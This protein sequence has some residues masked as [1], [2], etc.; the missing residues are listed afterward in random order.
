MPKIEKIKKPQNIKLIAITTILL[1][2][3]VFGL[4]QINALFSNNKKLESDIIKR[5][6]ELSKF[7]DISSLKKTADSEITQTESEIASIKDKFF[8]NVEDIFFSLSRFAEAN[9]ISIKAINPLEKIETKIP[10]SSDVYLELPITI[11]LECNFY[12]LLAFLNNIEALK[13]TALINKI[14]IQSN[15]SNIWEHDIEISLKLPLVAKN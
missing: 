6:K 15:P 13:K 12:Q 10:N 5:T 8:S 14:K 11:K 3:N 4:S 9:G 1:I 7:S 2:I